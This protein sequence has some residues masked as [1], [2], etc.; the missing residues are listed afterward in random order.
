[1]ALRAELGEPGPAR[2]VSLP[3]DP[4][5][6]SFQ[7]CALAGLGPMDAQQLLEIDDADQRL[8]TLAGR[9]DEHVAVLEFRLADG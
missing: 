1:V 3:S 2:D 7:A 8:Q 9:L 4:V 5:H 6:A